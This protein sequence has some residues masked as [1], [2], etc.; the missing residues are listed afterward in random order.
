MGD[1]FSFLWERVRGVST[2][3]LLTGRS[4]TAQIT[5]TFITNIILSGAGLL[6]SALAARL[7]GV[8]GRGELAAIQGWP[9]IIASIAMLGIPEA[10]VYFGQRKLAPIG[11]LT[12][13]GFALVLIIAIPFAAAGWIVMPFLLPAQSPQTIA[14]ARLYVSYIFLVVLSGLPF[15]A[16]RAAMELRRWNLMRLIGPVPWISV[17]VY[18]LWHGE[19]SSTSVALYFLIATAAFNLLVCV[20]SIPSIP[21]P[22]EVHMRYW[23]QLAGYG[24]PVLF[25]TLPQLLNLRLDQ[26]LMA[27]YLPPQP[28][29]M[30]VVAV[31][32]SSALLPLTGAFSSIVLPKVSGIEV[33]KQKQTIGKLF[34]ATSVLA[35]VIAAVLIAVTPIA[36]PFIFGEAFSSAVPVASILIVAAVFSGLNSVASESLKAIGRP[37]S[38][39]VGEIAGLLVTVVL[40]VFLLERYEAFG[41]AIASAVAYA[42]A[43][44]ILLWYLKSGLRR[45]AD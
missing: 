42:T 41:A 9:M 11:T 18:C 34:A 26:L 8:S 35:V 27:A 2:S 5:E 31:G 13:S 15:T 20:F 36:V 4:L 30:Y 12:F 21:P 38:V 40:L 10:V 16:F 45:N 6:T 1:R 32:W 7:L 24:A 28:L 19:R 17:L 44:V 25:S 3:E 43:F 33:S 23:P 37:G 39:V 22:R 14:L 29:G